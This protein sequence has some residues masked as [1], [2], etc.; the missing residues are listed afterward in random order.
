MGKRRR[1]IIIRL[2]F[3]KSALTVL[4]VCDQAEKWQST[5]AYLADECD[6]MI[7]KHLSTGLV[8][9][10]AIHEAKSDAKYV[11]DCVEFTREELKTVKGDNPTK[12]E[13]SDVFLCSAAVILLDDT[14]Q[15]SSIKM[16]KAIN[17]LIS[18]VSKIEIEM[19]KRGL[20]DDVRDEAVEFI[21]EI[22]AKGEEYETTT[23]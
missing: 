8:S 1:E 12:G 6:K 21:N 13:R 17:H 4:T 14:Y 22:Y 5:F 2:I 15:L 9:N 16:R 18:Q 10:K 20:L 3:T 23:G 11:D 19:D 7:T